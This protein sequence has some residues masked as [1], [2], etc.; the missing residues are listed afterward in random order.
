MSGLGLQLH[1]QPLRKR[2]SASRGMKSM[3]RAVGIFTRA[4]DDRI[5]VAGWGCKA[6]KAACPTHLGSPAVRRANRIDTMYFASR[7]ASAGIIF[8]IAGWRCHK[9]AATRRYIG[10]G[11]GRRYRWCQQRLPAA[12]CGSIKYHFIDGT[13]SS[14]M[15]RCVAGNAGADHLLGFTSRRSIRRRA[16]ASLHRMAVHRLANSGCPLAAH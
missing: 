15:L 3:R 14:S 2:F 8:S 13:S 1:F 9:Y 6:M 7:R 10:R 12:R 4:K 16:K 5:L 11:R